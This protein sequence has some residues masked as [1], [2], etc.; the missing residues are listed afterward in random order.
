MLKWLDLARI[1]IK[2]QG[3]GNDVKIVVVE[4]EN[5]NVTRPQ[6]FAKGGTGYV[7][8]TSD[9]HIVFELECQR[10]GNLIIR[11][12]GIDRHVLG[13]DRLPLWVDYTKLVINGEELI[14]EVQPL[15]HDKSYSCTRQ[16][17]DGEKIG[18]KIEWKTHVYKE[19]E[20]LQLLSLWLV[21]PVMVLAAHPREEIGMEAASYTPDILWAQI[22]HDTIISSKWLLDK[23]IS[24]GGKRGWAVGYNFLYV[25]YRV[26]EEM[27]PRCILELG[28]GQSTKLTSQ[29]VGYYNAEHVVVEHDVE[30]EKFFRR[31]FI[32]SPAT[33]VE[34]RNLIEREYNK[35][36]YYAYD[37][38]ASVIKSLTV[39]CG[40]ILIDGPFGNRSERSR[41]D[42]IPFLPSIL[43]EDFVIMVDD[44]GRDGEANLLKE[45]K[46][47]LT[48]GSIDYEEGLY[49][50][51]GNCHVGVI[52]CRKWRFFT[53]M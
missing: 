6:W 45:I 34:R 24:P 53:S 44:C 36:R 30:W 25:L 1:D 10:A 52:A 4:G 2:N 51:S 31:S 47:I 28:L 19:A 14:K 15:W 21:D 40:L 35:A 49:K 5:C 41:R 38:F 37:D 48:D 26:L 20:L 39:P 22:Y 42:I 11:L 7:V 32:L 29:Y 50:S 17:T 43:A 18:V 9:K 12:Q 27:K 8:E 13:R 3:E 33:R 16:V 46:E 23:A